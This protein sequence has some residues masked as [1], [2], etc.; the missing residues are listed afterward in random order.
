MPK[1]KSAEVPTSIE[2]LVESIGFDLSGTNQYRR[3]QQ[4]YANDRIAF[5]HDCMPEV[6][7][8]IAPYQEEILGYFDEGKSRV[9]I[10]GPHGLGKT[11]LASVLVH[12]AVLT[13][14][15]DCKV[16]TTASAWRQLEKYLWP[17][18]NKLEKLIA[19]HVVGRP[20]YDRRSEFLQL[21]I[22][23]KDRDVEAF[24]LASDDHTTLEGAH[25]TLVMFV[26]DEAKT[27]P[28]PT[29]DAVEGA[30][31]SEGLSDEYK[32]LAFAISTPGDPSGRFYDIHSHKPG[33][34]DWT[35]RHV[36]IGEAIAAGRISEAW[37]EQRRRQW[38]E[39][40]PVFQNRVLGEFADNTE[41]GVI[42]L[43]W[44]NAAIARGQ[45]DSINAINLQERNELEAQNGSNGA[46]PPPTGG[47]EPIS[48]DSEISRRGIDSI[49]AIRYAGVD[50]AR[51]GRDSTVIARRIALVLENIDQFRKSPTTETAG[52][53]SNL[54]RNHVIN[55][56]MD[57]YGA[58][59][60]DILKERGIPN[61]RPIHPNAKTWKTDQSGELTFLNT[62]AAMWWNMRE[63][64]DPANNTGIVLPDHPE[65]VADLVTPRWST[66]STGK[67]KIEAKVDLKKR[68]G[69]SPD[70]GDAVCLAFW[71]ASSGGGIVF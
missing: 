61:L 18:I 7:A 52:R 2:E 65:M 17:E 15:N 3:F 71:K 29:W 69:R 36:T 25:A 57:G 35:T 58:G 21:S 38:G 23:I 41:D 24:A 44:I 16:P 1:L 33:Y 30:F 45:R 37:V 46:H 9:A 49:N 5:V 26:F 47:I 11:F 42:P 67:I 63:L 6:S 43:S 51:M 66:T 28:V 13:S 59:V 8:T 34:E 19:W 64:L 4:L 55:I 22:K 54:C 56:E 31:S 50:V 40:N 20:K 27:I 62:R 32:A 60:Y 68:L 53:V 39:D 10:R 14:E 70:V 48:E 12:H